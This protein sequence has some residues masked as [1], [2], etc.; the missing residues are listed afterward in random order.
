MKG[1]KLYSDLMKTTR[2][3]V[4]RGKYYFLLKNTLFVSS[5]GVNLIF[6]RRMIIKKDS[7][8]SFDKYNLNF[9]NEIEIKTASAEQRD[10]IY[11]INNI[12]KRSYE[13]TFAAIIK[14]HEQVKLNK[15]I[16]FIEHVN[17]AAVPETELQF[18]L[19]QRVN[20]VVVSEIKL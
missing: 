5:F 10:G 13:A 3:M 19:F 12:L 7:K 2:L 1:E 14:K 4:R 15:Y 9:Y 6:N 17:S 20:S 8:D 16:I 11:L 18:F